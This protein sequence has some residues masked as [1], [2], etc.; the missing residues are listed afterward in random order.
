MNWIHVFHVN[1][2]DTIVY[3]K[4]LILWSFLWWLWSWWLLW[5]SIS[6][7]CIHFNFHHFHHVTCFQE[8]C[9]EMCDIVFCCKRNYGCHKKICYGVNAYWCDTCG[10]VYRSKKSL[11]GHRR[12][13]HTGDVYH[14]TFFLC[15]M[16]TISISHI[17]DA[18]VDWEFFV[19]YMLWYSITESR[20]WEWWRYMDVW[21]ITVW[22]CRTRLQDGWGW[23]FGKFTFTINWQVICYEHVSSM[24]KCML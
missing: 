11:H 15:R 6:W 8:W 13:H 18:D 21:W 3:W 19:I 5:W 12:K 14:F 2:F 16:W 4:V 7:F 22:S 10:N 17:Y 20:T 24:S 1:A 23:W 9:C